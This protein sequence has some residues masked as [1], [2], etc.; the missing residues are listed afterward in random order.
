MS[1][2]NIQNFAQIYAKAFME[3]GALF[4]FGGYVTYLLLVL[5]SLLVLS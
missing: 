3:V 5:C 1:I 4:S 2:T